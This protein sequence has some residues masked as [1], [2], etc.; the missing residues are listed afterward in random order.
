MVLKGCAR[1]GGDLYREEGL[2]EADMVCIQ[3]GHRTGVARVEVRPKVA[4][5]RRGVSRELR[6]SVHR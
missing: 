6:N 3:C 5:A 2:G 4:V 1:C